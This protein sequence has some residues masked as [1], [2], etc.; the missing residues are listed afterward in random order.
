MHLVIEDSFIVGNLMLKSLKF[1]NVL[2]VEHFILFPKS[3][4]SFTFL[5]L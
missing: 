4:F 5:F 3:K 2:D 1:K